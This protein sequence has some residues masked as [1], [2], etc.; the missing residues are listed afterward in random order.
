MNKNDLFNAI[1][2]IDDDILARSETAKSYKPRL[3]LRIAAIAACLCILL[4]AAAVGLI[5]KF[6]SEKENSD[7]DSSSDIHSGKLDTGKPTSEKYKTLDELLA[8][9]SANDNHANTLG[10]GVATSSDSDGIEYFTKVYVKGDYKFEI[11]DS[12]PK[13]TQVGDEIRYEFI[14][15]EDKVH[16]KRIDEDGYYTNIVN[17][18]IDAER[19]ML[20]NDILIAENDYAIRFYSIT[21]PSNPSFITE[22][23]IERGA[24]LYRAEDELYFILSDG[25]CACGWSRTDD[26]S[27]YYPS[28]SHD[29]QT[30]KWGDENI[31]ILGE[32]TRVSYV[33]V[34]KLSLETFDVI[35]KHAYYGDIEEF[36]YGPDWFTI[37]TKTRKKSDGYV[38]NPDVYTFDTA[39]TLKH[40]GK[41][42]V[43]AIFGREKKV[44]LSE[45]GYADDIRMI[46]VAK[47]DGKIRIIG[48]DYI[49]DPK[50]DVNHHYV[51]MAMEADM[52]N[53]QYVSAEL[54]LDYTNPGFNQRL[55]ESGRTILTVNYD[56]KYEPDP[57]RNSTFIF[58]EFSDERVDII[59]S[60]MTAERVEGINSVGGITDAIV[61]IDN[62][63]YIRYNKDH[64]GFSV[65]D[66][67]DSRS[68]KLLH[69]AA[70]LIGESD[71][72][73]FSWIKYSEN[74]FGVARGTPTDFGFEADPTR[75]DI[76]WDIYSFDPTS[77]TPFTLVESKLVFEYCSQ[78]RF[79]IMS[80]DGTY[81]IVK[82]GG[83]TI[84]SVMPQQ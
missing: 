73:S 61:P 3:M 81:Y 23:T 35:D 29:G 21:D 18:D 28:Y 53:E 13:I 19:F 40:T 8:D 82:G 50:P 78:Y 20:Y 49:R 63:I 83:L 58:I 10:S 9:L 79:T 47:I 62:G 68:P 37:T 64:N 12:Y 43:A 25:V 36:N 59:P 55:N 80:I 65:Y 38:L 57:Y 77:E 56:D 33:A 24:S 52:A 11:A 5:Y 45:K 26:V 41:I 74:L 60:N 54:Y 71:F 44:F 32:P 27:E 4:S 51:L 22:Y 48:G 69:N 2:E 30:D 34:M 84:E 72:N 14:K 46:S 6:G 42:D 75:Y 16:I 31:S 17:R 39:K 70:P 76:Y 67:S 7:L 15:T 1:G 66:F